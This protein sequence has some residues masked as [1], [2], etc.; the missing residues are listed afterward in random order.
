MQLQSI[1][2]L[3]VVVYG[4]AS[5]HHRAL[6]VEARGQEPRA[7]F[8]VGP[9]HA[10]V[11]AGHLDGRH[12]LLDRHAEPGHR[13][14]AAPAASQNW[15]WWAFLLTGMLTVSSTPSSGGARG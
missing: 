15:L 7:I 5:S 1:D 13:H 2:W 14:R 9:E 6:V 10:L 12:D 8:P 3:I 11:A 4:V